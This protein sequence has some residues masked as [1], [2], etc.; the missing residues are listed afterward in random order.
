MIYIE[1]SL[2]SETLTRYLTVSNLDCRIPTIEIDKP[3]PIYYS[4]SVYLKTSTIDIVATVWVTCQV[5]QTYSKAWHVYTVDSVSGADT[6]SVDLSSNPTIRVNNLVIGSGRL[7][8]GLYRLSFTVKTKNTNFFLIFVV[9]V[10]NI[11][12]FNYVTFI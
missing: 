9:V 8:T 7:A 12:S 3:S 4:P 2:S 1:N 5:T 11:I 10:V 6:G